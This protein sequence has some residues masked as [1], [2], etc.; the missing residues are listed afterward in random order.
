MGTNVGSDDENE[1]EDESFFRK[2]V[3]SPDTLFS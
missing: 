2:I 1:M 3:I